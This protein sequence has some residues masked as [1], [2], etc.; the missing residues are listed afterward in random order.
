MLLKQKKKGLSTM[1]GIIFMTFLL[2][3]LF[4]F[5]YYMKAIETLKINMKDDA[6]M[7]TMAAVT[8]DLDKYGK[9]HNDLYCIGS[10]DFNNPNGERNSHKANA[11]EQ[12]EVYKHLNLYAKSLISTM[13]IKSAETDS[14]SGGNVGWAANA[15]GAKNFKLDNFKIYEYSKTKGIW[16]C[17][18]VT[19]EIKAVKLN[20]IKNNESNAF[21]G[22]IVEKK[23]VTEDEV[24]ADGVDTSKPSPTVCATFSFELC[25]PNLFA[26]TNPDVN[27]VNDLSIKSV[28]QTKEF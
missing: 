14:F 26:D 23:Q 8:V 27:R 19:G 28:S 1:I 9:D 2:F 5:S 12:N 21:N 10:T 24:K 3:I 7:A 25:L 22:L 6:D 17:Y 4:F 11:T 16:V 20:A 15:L 18:T 13:G